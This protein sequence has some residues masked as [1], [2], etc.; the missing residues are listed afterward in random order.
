M[1]RT[2]R[3]F[4]VLSAVCAAALLPLCADDSGLF[5]DGLWRGG[6]DLDDGRESLELRLFAPDPET[7][8]A[9][10]GLVDMPSRGLFGYPVG[11]LRRG[12]EGMSF[13]LLGDAPFSGVFDLSGAPSISAAGN[14]GAKGSLR[15]LA[16]PEPGAKVLAQ[17]RFDFVFEGASSRGDAFGSDYL[18]DTRRGF[19]RGSFLEPDA[20]RSGTALSVPV[21][22]I[23]SGAQADRDG[24]NYAVPGKSD[25]LA[26]LAVALR[27]EGVASLRFDKRGTGESYRLVPS[28]EKLRF[29]DHIDDA[30]AAILELARDSRFSSV[31]V[32]GFAEGALVGACALD[33]LF[34]S[35]KIVPSRV[36][37]LVSLCASGKS[38][39]EVATDA[40][41]ETPPELKAEAG[42][43]MAALKAGKIF[44]NPS[45]YFAGY[46]R[47]SGQPYLASLFARNIR[48]AVAA[49]PCRLFVIAGGSDLQTGAD[50]S[51]LLASSRSDADYRVVPGMGHTLK[52][53]GGDE[54]K[55]Y[56]SFTDP[57]FPLAPGLAEIV[58]AY[59][60]GKAAPG[61]QAAPRADPRPSSLSAGD[62]GAAAGG[63]IGAD[64]E[65]VTEG[66]APLE[67]GDQGDAR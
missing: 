18:I 43:I 36:S 23:I 66:D 20:L 57:S 2:T 51:E 35:G 11:D 50:E 5:I 7:G 34:A 16:G 58:A 44:P 48:T 32:A 63:A 42:A 31:L 67:G 55:N 3:A 26:Q 14:F 45:S 37:G 59:A 54:E 60:M 41:A 46:F 53:V 52:L 33:K 6:V 19:L 10:G 64:A 62:G 4:A 49:L 17:G 47:P 39:L 29:D 28:E 12:P 1:N 40:L 22:L 9:Q 30:A 38:E 15:L 25:S 13:T 27:S 21:V 61:G 8:D 65:Y 56:A 24:N